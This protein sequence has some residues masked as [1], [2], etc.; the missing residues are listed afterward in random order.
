[1]EDA[2]RYGSV[3]ICFAYAVRFATFQPNTLRRDAWMM[4]AFTW[5][6]DTIYTQSLIVTVILNS[7]FSQLR[8]LQHITSHHTA[9]FTC[10]I[11]ATLV[12]AQR[13][14]A[15]PPS[16]LTAALKL[17]YLLSCACMCF[18]LTYKYL[19]KQTNLLIFINKTGFFCISE[20]F[21]LHL[22]QRLGKR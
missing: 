16:A 22:H 3:F 15:S 5:F 4:C 17:C 8:A 6:Y 11:Y 18:I 19:D 2:Q 20:F 10:Q 9:H 13:C 14:Y 21:T 1:M 7:F 12:G